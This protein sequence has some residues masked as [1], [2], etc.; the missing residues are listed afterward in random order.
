MLHEIIFYDDTRPSSWEDLTVRRYALLKTDLGVVE[1][2]RLAAEA[3]RAKEEA[4][5]QELKRKQEEAAAELEEQQRVRREAEKQKIR[6]H[7]DH[8]VAQA[9][10]LGEEDATELLRSEDVQALLIMK[11]QQI[12]EQHILGRAFIGGEAKFIEDDQALEEAKK[13]FVKK[14]VNQHVEEVRERYRHDHANRKEAEAKQAAQE[15]LE[16][17]RLKEDFLARERELHHERREAFE[18][19]RTELRKS[20]TIP[21][22]DK[23]LPPVT[24]CEHNFDIR[25]WGGKYGNGIIC[26]KCKTELTQ[27]YRDQS[28]L[29]GIDAQMEEAVQRHREE[30]GAFRFTSA[31][32][33]RSVKNERLRLE[34]EDREQELAEDGFYD[35]M[36]QKRV[37]EFYRRHCHD[38][39]T[40][41]QEWETQVKKMVFKADYDSSLIGKLP[42]TASGFRSMDPEEIV[43][44][45]YAMVIT[46]PPERCYAERRRVAFR[47]QLAQYSRIRAF[48][49]RLVQ[50]KDVKQVL[51]SERRMRQENLVVLYKDYNRIERDMDIVEEEHLRARQFLKALEVATEMHT[52]TLA[53]LEE[54][55]AEKETAGIELE[56]LE[57]LCKVE[58][59]HMEE[60]SQ[61]VREIIVW[62]ATEKKSCAESKQL[63]DKYVKRASRLKEALVLLERIPLTLTYR[64]QKRRLKTPYGYG[65]TIFYRDGTRNETQTMLTKAKAILSS[66]GDE[67][68][69]VEEK[70]DEVIKWGCKVCGKQNMIESR[71]CVACKT[72]K[73][74]RLAQEH[75]KFFAKGNEEVEA[76]KKAEDDL[77][78][79]LEAPEWTCPTCKKVNL[80]ADKRCRD[81]RKWRPR[82]RLPGAKKK[83]GAAG[84]GDGAAG[85]SGG[86]EE[87]VDSEAT[88]VETI[89]LKLQWGGYS[90]AKVYMPV[91]K[92]LKMEMGR[93]K[94]ESDQMAVEDERAK[95][96]RS[97]E[98]G[99]K[100]R[101]LKQMAVEDE[102]MKE[103][104][105]R[106]ELDARIQAEIDIEVT[107]AKLT[108]PI[109]L[110]MGWKQDELAEMASMEIEHKAA[111]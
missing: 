73:P 66:D 41:E 10:T 95:K 81:C 56:Q 74:I 96:L 38:I 84:G 36:H 21:S 1:A 110:E 26:K 6:E 18:E 29:F 8:D 46:G 51:D 107:E 100:D 105:Y 48:N 76:Q 102:L 62:K 103:Y 53:D 35:L 45:Q 86:A 55:N 49:I 77:K 92:L 97:F 106:T 17:D 9:K 67:E 44:H 65:V 16:K 30:G 13:R 61:G 57:E 59:A 79:R 22:F 69:V 94:H 63:M 111:E 98:R 70:K 33:L 27:S 91:Q 31:K 52:T 99:V 39:D 12:K 72:K 108:A 37:H 50:M 19:Q 25:F 104:I 87:A 54:A 34:K 60:A 47:D 40:A 11:V 88:E 90:Y 64:R 101:E 32:Q 93:S 82:E 23:A 75:A 24:R 7:Y 43:E 2:Q 78:R 3:K 20:M 89:V 71:A 15:A 83:D 109:V 68:E 85:G 14:I 5:R 4:A 28:Q 80:K 58:E 42:I